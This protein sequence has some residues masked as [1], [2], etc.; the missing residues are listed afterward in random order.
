MIRYF[1]LTLLFPSSF[2]LAQKIEIPPELIHKTANHHAVYVNKNGS[3]YGNPINCYSIEVEFHEAKLDTVSR[4][5]SF[6]GTV[7]LLLPEDEG[8][9]ENVKI[10]LARPSKK[11]LKHIRVVGRS[12]LSSTNYLARGNFF[13]HFKL[14]RGERLYFEG[15]DKACLLEFDISRIAN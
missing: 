8:R 14:R 12:A 2:L 10:F 13:I 6:S 4:D 3:Y 5:F 9:L 11:N 7:F 15:D 1:I